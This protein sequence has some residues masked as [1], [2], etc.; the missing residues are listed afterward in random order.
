MRISELAAATNEPARTLRFY[1]AEGLLS[2]P[3]RTASGYRDY[4]PSAVDQVRA[5]RALQHAGLSLDE[6]ATLTHI[7]DTPGP[8]SGND[9]ALVASAQSLVDNQ[10]DRLSRMRSHL[11]TLAHRTGVCRDRLN[12]NTSTDSPSPSSPNN[13]QNN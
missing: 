2:P 5:V 12:D 1:E 3:R 10:L 6:I 4:D 8:V 9:A 13:P 11:A 7:R